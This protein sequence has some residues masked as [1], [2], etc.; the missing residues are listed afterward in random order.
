MPVFTATS[1][2]Y[3]TLPL[4]VIRDFGVDVQ[5]RFGTELSHVIDHSGEQ[6]CAYPLF[7]P[8]LPDVEHIDP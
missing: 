6:L 1:L 2:D 3:P 4:V 7:S 8:I 5:A